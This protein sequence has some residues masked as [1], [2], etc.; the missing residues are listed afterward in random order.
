MI[1]YIKNPQVSTP[2]QLEIIS[3]LTKVAGYEINIQ[4][5]VVFLC[6]GNKIEKRK[7]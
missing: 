5:S 1:P 7:F 2:K 4:K 6:I 3:E